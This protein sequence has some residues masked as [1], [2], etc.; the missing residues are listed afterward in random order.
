MKTIVTISRH[1][2]NPKIT[3][4]ISLEG[5]ALQMNLDDFIIALKQEIGSITTT[6]TQKTFSLKIDNAVSMILKRV[7][8]ESIKVV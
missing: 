6:F 2:N 4:T 8:E 1:W 7:K 3:T 5:I